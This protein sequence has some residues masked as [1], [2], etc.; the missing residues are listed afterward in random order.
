MKRS[1]ARARKLAAVVATSLV[2]VSLGAI[3]AF[4]QSSGSFNFNYDETACTD[5][6]GQLGGGTIPTVLDTTMKVSSG[7]GVALVVRP[8]AV[9]GL[10]TNASMSGKLGGGIST[11]SA[12]AGVTFSVAT[13]S[14]N[15][16]AK[17]TVIP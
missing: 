7:N 6:G 11:G 4:A 16:K 13:A 17:P 14:F 8:S 12:Q 3:Q 2:F 5:V 10:L 1:G 9:P 15:E